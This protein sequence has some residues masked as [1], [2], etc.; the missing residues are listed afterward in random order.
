[1]ELGSVCEQN[2]LE[3]K[4]YLSVEVVCREYARNPQYIIKQDTLSRAMQIGILDSSLDLKKFLR[5]QR[6]RFI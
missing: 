2:Y 3:F 1:M 6:S 5:G 4:D